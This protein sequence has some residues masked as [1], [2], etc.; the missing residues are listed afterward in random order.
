MIEVLKLTAALLT[1]TS[2]GQVVYVYDIPCGKVVSDVPPWEDLDET[3]DSE[4]LWVLDGTCSQWSRW[5]K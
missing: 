1:Y 4:T 5:R 3:N 2:G